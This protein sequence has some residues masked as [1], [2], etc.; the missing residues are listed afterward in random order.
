MNR[1]LN[2]FI[3]FGLIA[4]LAVGSFAADQPKIKVQAEQLDL[5]TEPQGALGSP[6]V[7]FPKGLSKAALAGTYTIGALGNYMTLN[8]AV[9]ALML[10]GVSAPVTFEFIDAAYA[11]SQVTFG[12]ITGAS[13]TNTVTFKPAVGVSPHIKFFNRRAN[14]TTDVTAMTFHGAGFITFDGENR[15]TIEA[16]TL[17]APWGGLLTSR[18]VLW[19]RNGSNNLNFKNFTAIGSRRSTSTGFALFYQFNTGYLIA[20]SNITYDNLTAYRGNSGFWVTGAS[21]AVPAPPDN[22]ITIKNCRIGGT[23]SPNPALFQLHLAGIPVSS[24]FVTNMTVDNNRFDGVMNA[25]TIRGGQ[26]TDNSVNLVVSNNIFANFVETTGGTS[27]N[28]I[29][30]LQVHG[31]AGLVGAVKSTMTFYNNMVYNLVNDFGGSAN[32]PMFGMIFFGGNG[33]GYNIKLYHNTFNV[34]AKNTNMGSS[35]GMNY[36]GAGSSA[37]PPAP[38][39]DIFDVKNNIFSSRRTSAGNAY[40]VAMYGPPLSIIGAI[41]LT[42]DNNLYYSSSTYIGIIPSATPNSG[43]LFSSLQDW[44]DSAGYWTNGLGAQ[45]DVNSKVGDPLFKPNDGRI[46]YQGYVSP[47]DLMGT[48]S[49]P[50]YITH[51]IDGELRADK[52]PVDVGA[53]AFTPIPWDR[54]AYPVSITGP[55]PAGIIFNTDGY[56]VV[57]VKSNGTETFGIATRVR[58][59]GPAPATTEVYNVV[60]TTPAVDPFAVV[61]YTFTVP[62]NTATAGTYTMYLTTELVGDQLP[63]NNGPITKSLFVS[64]L[65]VAPYFNNFET[66]VGDWYSA[67]TAGTMNDWLLGTPAK[68]TINTAASGVKAWVT[69]PLN[70]NYA[71][72]WQGAVYSPY[73]DLTTLNN[74]VLRFDMAFMMEPDWDATIVEYTLDQGATW[75]RADRAT[76]INWYNDRDDPDLYLIFGAPAWSG[77]FETNPGG[78]RKATITLSELANV[79]LVRF[80][81]KFGSDAFSVDEGVAFDN[82]EVLDGAKLAGM[83]FLD[84]NQNGA[85][86]TGEPGTAGWNVNLKPYNYIGTSDANGQYMFPDNI[87]PG[88]YTLYE[89]QKPGWVLTYPSNLLQEHEIE[90]TG[91]GIIGDLDFGNYFTNASISG[92]KFED[93][94]G[95]GIKETGEPGLAGWTINLAGPMTASVVTPAGGAYSFTSLLPGDYTV[96]EDLQAGWVKTLPTAASYAV[97]LDL[98]GQAVVDQDFGNF[99]L[100]VVS[101][102]VFLDFNR[103]GLFNVGE[104]G[105]DDVTVN[106]NTLTTVTAGGGLYNFA[107]PV[108]SYTLSIVVPSGRYI[109]APAS[110]NY[111][112]NV[113]ASGVVFAGNFALN[114]DEDQAMYRS[115]R[116]EDI[117]ALVNSKLPKAIKNTKPDKVEFELELTVPVHTPTFTT[118]H[119]EYGAAPFAT[120]DIKYPGQI[121]PAQ[122]V[123]LNGEELELGVDYTLTGVIDGKNKKFDY[124]IGGLAAGDTINIHGFVK[125]AK[126]IKAKYWWLPVDLVAKEKIVKIA[127]LGTESVWNLNMPRLPMPTYANLIN[128][129][130]T[131]G[132]FTLPDAGLLVGIVGDPKTTGWVLIA[133]PGDVQ[134]SLYDKNGGIHDGPARFFDFLKITKPFVKGQKTLPPIVHDNMLFAEI[135]ALKLGIAASATSHTL[136]GFGELVYQGSVVAHHGKKVSTIAKQ[137]SDAMTLKPTEAGL[138][139][140][141]FTAIREINEAFAGNLDTT[142]FSTKTVLTGIK[143]LADVPV[144]RA[145]DGTIVTINTPN[146]GNY[147]QV[148]DIFELAQNYPNPFNPS[149]TIQFI[150]PEDAIVTLKVYNVLGQE[151]ATLANRELFT[152]GLNDVEFEAG[153]LSSG[154]YFYQITADGVGENAAK[155]S[156]IKKM[157]LMK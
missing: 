77:S 10:E 128:E 80:R 13:L 7:V 146:E 33:Q 139:I 42:S 104:P 122:V 156:Q 86:D 43:Y 144:L 105:V 152:E 66:T 94:N 96:S 120:T 82:F 119:L 36:N 20:N 19:V 3:L 106:L 100:A 75:V 11:D 68:T 51:D 141:Y 65:A 53:D 18:N 88:I 38:G 90:V 123:K 73:L 157:V 93:L 154:V 89:D 47:A 56:P 99:K 134:K 83:F 130:Y 114:Y 71:V 76:A 115:F 109:I 132:G 124:V 24:Q 61:S 102:K 112:I 37:V 14:L 98:G 133:K 142:N 138:A 5:V 131:D 58:I 46:V 22:N 110:G 149:T 39:V 126:P 116:H 117:V 41:N 25:A 1:F 95:N 78:W 21:S 135:V 145:G 57:R 6:L 140:G 4:V 45:V 143:K 111:P 87:V 2:L 34:D 27:T 137:A 30:A 69:G 150:L 67:P 72:A 108:A 62:F 136:P 44:R 97:T 15:M 147:S 70:A 74:P 32:A 64:P 103:D 17:V 129:V 16:D 23:F 55:D 35:H 49:V 28:S 79:P 50:A 9:A 118:L 81:V 60:E 153:N 54:D 63:E 113:N 52:T 127:L 84:V 85:K 26:F 31:T 121:F 40:C 12:A 59:V 101:G 125:S 155:F 48:A 148:P 107:A 92:M 151:V 8:E 29:R 91:G